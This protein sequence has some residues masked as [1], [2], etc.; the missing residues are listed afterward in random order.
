MCLTRLT[1]RL[2]NA[3]YLFHPHSS[4]QPQSA[5]IDGDDLLLDIGVT[6][7]SYG[8]HRKDVFDFRGSSDGSG[9]F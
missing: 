3:L 4:Y 5:G 9:I 7:R 6:G 8:F 1:F 2:T